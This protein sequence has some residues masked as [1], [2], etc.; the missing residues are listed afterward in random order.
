MNGNERDDALAG[1]RDFKQPSILSEDEG[2]RKTLSMFD[3]LA[4]VTFPRL[5]GSPAY[6][7]QFSLPS[8]SALLGW[9][10]SMLQ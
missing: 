8:L 7:K 3:R 6:M 5:A 4:G 2:E 9:P 10:H 1:G